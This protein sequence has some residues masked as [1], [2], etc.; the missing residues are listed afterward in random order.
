MGPIAFVL[1]MVV[2]GPLAKRFTFKIFNPAETKP[3]FLILSISV[4]SVMFMCP[5]MSL[6]ATILFSCSFSSSDIRKPIVLFR[7]LFFLSLHLST[8]HPPFII[9]FVRHFRLLG[10]EKVCIAVCNIYAFMTDPVGNSQSG[11]THFYK[12]T[13]VAMPEVMDTN[14]FYPAFLCSPVHFVMQIG[15]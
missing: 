3:I 4:L 11:K 8:I 1:D 2:A 13:Y 12:K 15:L 9:Q 10:R 14:P 6:A 7:H 5:L